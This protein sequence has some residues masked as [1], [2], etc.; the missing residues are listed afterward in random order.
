MP[1]AHMPKA[2]FADLIALPEAAW[3]PHINFCLQLLFKSR[4]AANGATFSPNKEN[5]SYE[6]N[7]CVIGAS[8]GLRDADVRPGDEQRHRNDRR[9]LRPEVCETGRRQ[10]SLRHFLHRK[11]WERGICG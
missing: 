5:K 10:G 9:D 2:H 3:V 1:T 7:S 11:Q 8:S 4:I 6:K